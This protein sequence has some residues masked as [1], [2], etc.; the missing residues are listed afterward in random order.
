[1]LFQVRLAVLRTCGVG[2]SKHALSKSSYA[3]LPCIESNVLLLHISVQNHLMLWL[4]Y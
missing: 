3:S 2:V 4:K 1:M